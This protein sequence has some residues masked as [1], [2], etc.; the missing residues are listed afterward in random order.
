[1]CV[2]QSLCFI[3]ARHYDTDVNHLAT[4]TASPFHFAYSANANARRTALQS[5]EFIKQTYQLQHK[6]ENIGIGWP[7]EQKG[8]RN[9]LYTKVNEKKK[10]K[11]KN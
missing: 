8:E 4:F 9:V 2:Q 3:T 6:Y 7:T 5:V 11:K 1:M 10:K